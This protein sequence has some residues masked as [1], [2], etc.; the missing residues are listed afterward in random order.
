MFAW[1]KYSYVASWSVFF[2]LAVS[3]GCFAD[4]AFAQQHAF[5]IED[6]HALL[7]A[8]QMQFA[9]DGSPVVR[10]RIAEN[11]T[12]IRFSPSASFY[13]YPDGPG[14]SYIELPG[15]ETYTIEGYAPQPGQYRFAVILARSRNTNELDV[16][17]ER[18]AQIVPETETISLGSIF[19]L[20]GKVF[21][22]REHLRISL[23]TNDE[24]EAALLL[25]TLKQKFPDS[26][27]EIYDELQSYPRLT[28]SLS[29]ARGT[30][31]VVNANLMWLNFNETIVTVHNMPDEQGKAQNLLL[32][33]QLIVT[34]DSNA[35]L[36]LV[37][38]ASVE[39]ILRGILPAELYPTAPAAALESQA[40]A[41]RTTL[42]SQVGARHQADPYHLCN[43]QHCQVY[44]GLGVA[45]PATD[46]AIQ[47]TR[48]Q[49]LFSDEQLVQAYYSSHCGGS[50]ATA[51]ETWNL[52]DVPYLVAR[53][54]DDSES[55][56]SPNSEYVQT[57]ISKP[58]KQ[59][60]AYC[61][62]APHG[63]KDFTSTKN[64][65]WVVTVDRDVLLASLQKQG[66]NIK[67]V[68]VIEILNRG[69][70]G[71]VTRMRVVGDGQELILEHELPIRRFFGGL[72]SALFTMSITRMGNNIQSVTF[73]GAGFG[74]GVGLCQ[75]GAIGMAQRKFSAAQ[76]L[77]HYYP[78]THIEKLW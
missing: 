47:K 42:I 77:Q 49:V 15:D 41:A 62:H 1:F 52:P 70:S 18:Y 57:I 32:N 28:V 48:G 21:D 61:A 50:S 25:N 2:C 69:Q 56:A 51:Y 72:K 46:Q 76:I 11:Q 7:Y 38:A 35:K 73:E 16:L 37:Q 29:N 31:R 40:I 8:K 23:R 45:T 60:T 17:T 66:L 20:K 24:T 55:P 30:T 12:Q 39:T 43:V 5:T 34:P 54:D 74:H 65:H 44:R 9:S 75:T 64:A 4:K 53:R 33:G 58:V 78:N 71:R 10:M 19:A 13:V 68:Q 59:S 3:C 36:S 22:N 6:N 14:G 27:F 67:S 63:Q 26:D